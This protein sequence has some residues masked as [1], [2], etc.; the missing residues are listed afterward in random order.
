LLFEVNRFNWTERIAF[1]THQAVI[2]IEYSD[3]R[4]SSRERDADGSVRPQIH[5]ERVR[6]GNRAGVLT[7]P[8]SGAG[9][10]IDVS[11]LFE[12]FCNEITPVLIDGL[13]LAVGEKMD[14]LV[15]SDSR[16]FGCG[17]T[18][19]TIQGRENFAQGNHF[20]PNASLPLHQGDLIALIGQIQRTLHA[21]NPA[22]HYKGI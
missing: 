22:A 4:N 5:I 18:T 11:G 16:H 19:A 14:V 3:L 2:H 10:F 13:Y 6:Q 8:A 17:D 12:D 7:L 9:V 15:M 1:A 21:R 20:A